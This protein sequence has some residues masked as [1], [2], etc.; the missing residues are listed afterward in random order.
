MVDVRVCFVDSLF[1]VY[2]GVNFMYSCSQHGRWQ[3]TDGIRESW[4]RKAFI[5]GAL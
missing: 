3:T 5:F 2:S 1:R 4:R